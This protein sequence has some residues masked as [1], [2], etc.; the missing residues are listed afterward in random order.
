[1]NGFKGFDKDMKCRG[2][3]Y[4]VGEIFEEAE[5]NLCHKGMHYCEAPGHVFGYYSA[6]DSRFCEVEAEEMAPETRDDSKRVC[7][8]LK[9]G[10]EISA[11]DICKMAVKGFFE[12]FSFDSKIDK[13]KES[14][15]TNAGNYGAANAGNYGAANAGN[16]GA[17]NAG[18]YGAANA[19][20]RGAANAGYRG[21]A[22]AGNCGAANAGD[23]G[24]AIV[25]SEGRASVGKDGVAIC[26]GNSGRAKGLL[27]AVLILIER[28]DDG[29]ITTLKT[30]KVDGK[31]IKADT[32]Y[33][34]EGGKFVKAEEAATNE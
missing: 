12:W 22:N 24:A 8:R 33:R 11:T 34:L 4:A 9:I 6:G 1:M 26:M 3:Q 17:A 20:D 13:S 16:Y 2:K 21:A 28:N 15:E 10:A 32:W 19:G 25:Q 7:K 29:E 18:N 30:A 31:K 5:V 27:G 14:P 23:R